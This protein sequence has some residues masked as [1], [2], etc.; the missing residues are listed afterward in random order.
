MTSRL[1]HSLT[2]LRAL[3]AKEFRQLLRDKRMRFLL[4]GPPLIQLVVFGYA[5]TFD[6]RE[7]D[8]AVVDAAHTHATRKIAAARQASCC[9]RTSV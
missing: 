5:A 6:V 9:H 4:V 2:R 7:V 3:L 1:R 8:I